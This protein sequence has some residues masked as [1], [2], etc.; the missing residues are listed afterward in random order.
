MFVL[1]QTEDNLRRINHKQD[2][3][4]FKFKLLLEL[5]FLLSS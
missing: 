2:N 4:L 1:K 3:D 5:K